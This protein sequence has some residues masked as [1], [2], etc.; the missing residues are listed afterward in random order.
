MQPVGSCNNKVICIANMAKYH[1]SVINDC[2]DIDTF[3]GQ[4]LYYNTILWG[5]RIIN[6]V[7]S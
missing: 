4:T 2:I 1:G 5:K 7:D 6:A 3:I